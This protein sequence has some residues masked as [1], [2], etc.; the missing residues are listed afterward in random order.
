MWRNY[1]TVAVR[2]LAKSKTYSIINIAGLAIGMAACIMILLYIR[3]EQSYDNWL[4]DAENTYQLQAWYPN[5]SSGIPILSQMSAYVTK[6][7][8]KKDFPQVERVGYLLDTAPVILKD[9]QATLAENYGLADDD[10]LQVIKLPML[11]GSSLPA[12]GT[13]VLSQSEAIKQ[14]GT[15][16]VV[17]R[18]LTTVSKG[19]TQD[20]K[21]T[22]VFK[23]IPKNSHMKLN[24]ILR[25]DFNSY[26]SDS[27]S[28]LTQWGWQ[29]GWVYMTLRPGSDPKV[30]DA[31]IP[32]WEKR[33][34]PDETNEGIRTNQG[35]DQDWHFVNVRD[36]HLG[37]A[38]NGAMTPGNDQRTV[39][40]FAIIA[41]LIL[42]M[43]IV[44]FTNLATARASQRAREVALRKVL[45]ANRKQ[46]VLQFV[47]EAMLISAVSMLVGLALVE[48]L[49]RPFAAFLDADLEFSYFGAGG[50]LLPA[51]GITLLVGFASGLY[52]A[53]FLSRFQPAHVL[54]AN[55]SAA[56]TPGSGRLRT[57]LVVAQFAVSIGLIVCTAVVYAQTVYA[58]SADPGYKRDHI[59]Q[60]DNINR[61]Q[62]AS[63]G[64]MIVDQ[65]K[66]VPGVVAVGR[67][68]IGVSTGNNINTGVV[69]PG[70]TETVDIGS[71]EVDEGFFDAMGLS[72]KA[73]RWFD[74][75]RPA[76]DQTVPFPSDPAAEKLVAARGV[77]VVLN[78]LAVKRL[79]FKSTRDAIGKT[80][81]A[82][83]FSDGVP[84]TDLSVIGV[85][86]DTQ[87]RSVRDPVQ[88]IMFG[89]VN[90]GPGWM[91]I[92]Y[93]GDPQSVR[94]AVEQKWKQIA[95]EVPFDAKFS[96][97]IVSN[98]YEAE[99]A[100]AQIFAAFSLLAVFIGCLGLFGL[101]AFTAERRTKEIGIRKVLGARTRDIVRLL[102]W[103]FSRPVIVANLIAWPVAWWVMRDWLN[104]F[105][106]R[107]TLGPTPFITAALIALTIA[108][109]TVVGHAFKVARANPIH[110]L[111]YE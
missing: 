94:A 20:S 86:G 69:P 107:I 106:Q 99:D 59:L 8:I 90:S 49:V 83:I 9:G 62:L 103:Q 98:L 45:G 65:M 85:V 6:D 42:G 34:I 1:W 12:A 47:G 31:A 54:K 110:A 13:A 108:I 68:G 63:R 43:A 52:P 61:R 2:A 81:R 92:R 64:E 60:V 84:A 79:G 17:G 70:A 80:F 93:N 10:I 41:L 97:D 14:F 40:T 91:I 88:P 100:R 73:G 46:L 102:V 89:N 11:A 57:A 101:A 4:P 74:P 3:Y 53:F 76:D 24:A 5:P 48:L 16:K 72:L 96:E 104:G 28:F 111:R 18:T 67:T 105:D 25:T 36:I 44:N 21:I 22:G 23:D 58:R 109:V 77:N 27:P 38:Q 39:T 95:S 82:E 78:E 35:D 87:F 19:V 51:I 66:S 15:D 30:L 50:I 37:K 7:R 26:W 71:Y 33:N 55:R 75:N 32:A 56:E 29:S